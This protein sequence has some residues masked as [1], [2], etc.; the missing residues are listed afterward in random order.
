MEPN[1]NVRKTY[2][3]GKLWLFDNEFTFYVGY[4][5]AYT[6]T[7]TKF[8]WF[9]EEILKALCIFRRN[10]ISKIQMMV[11]MQDPLEY[12]LKYVREKDPLYR[13]FESNDLDRVKYAKKLIVESRFH[14]RLKLVMSWVEYCKNL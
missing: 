9:H 11:D 8:F 7:Y 5:Y 3:A 2:D 10:T 1:R 12:L 13:I 6:P 14:E 4:D